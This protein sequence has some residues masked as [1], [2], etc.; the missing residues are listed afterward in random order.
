MLYCFLVLQN[1]N[2][3]VALIKIFGKHNVYIFEWMS[4]EG[5]RNKFATLVNHV[6]HGILNQFF[7]LTLL[8]FGKNLIPWY[9]HV[10][11]P[12]APSLYVAMI[13]L[14]DFAAQ[15]ARKM[16]SQCKFETCRVTGCQRSTMVITSDNGSSVSLCLPHCTQRVSC[17]EHCSLFVQHLAN[18]LG[19]PVCFGYCFENLLL[20]LCNHVFNG[21]CHEHDFIVATLVIG[22]AKI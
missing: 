9:L 13:L 10:P 4:K 15:V 20:T 7:Y 21:I 8:H 14:S 3:F 2:W 16:A 17:M 6:F 22:Q 11:L 1:C 12:R 18:Q 19:I 5:T